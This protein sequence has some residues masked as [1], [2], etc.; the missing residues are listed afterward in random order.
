MFIDK[1]VA[2]AEAPISWPPD[3]KS[4]LIGKDS[5]AGKDWGKEEKVEGRG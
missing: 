5:D 2:E 3:A 4:H 1:T